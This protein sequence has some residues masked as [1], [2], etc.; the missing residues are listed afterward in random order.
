[1]SEEK[2]IMTDRGRASVRISGQ[3]SPVIALHGWLD[4]AASFTELAPL[5]K[6][7]TVFAPD[8][9]GHGFSDHL[10]PGQRYHYLDFLPF[11]DSAARSLELESFILLGHSMGAGLAS[12]Y[13]AAYPEKVE[14]LIL[15]EGLG[16]LSADKGDTAAS[17]RKSIGQMVSL[18]SKRLPLYPDR[19]TAD[20]AR[21]RKGDLSARSVRLLHERALKK[22]DGGYTWRSDP[23]M[24]VASLMRMHEE[25][26]NEALRAIACPVLLL[27]GSRGMPSFLKYL[28]KR[29][30]L[31]KSIQIHE[32]DGGHH[33]HL[34]NPVETAKVINL[35]LSSETPQ[36]SR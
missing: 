27:K 12:L 1:M 24:K 13:A 33:L 5:L 9:P 29:I 25:Q 7:C 16:P 21:I 18:E 3:G 22:V 34:E 11:I 28:E 14:K 4:N 17:L 10:P 2:S 35:F 23:R 8:F 30:N 15:I 6:N 32:I 26:V 19:D 31:V 20:R 36:G